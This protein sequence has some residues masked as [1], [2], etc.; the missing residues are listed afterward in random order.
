MHCTQTCKQTFKHRGVLKK[1]DCCTSNKK[2]EKPHKRK[3]TKIF[4]SFKDFAFMTH[5]RVSNHSNKKCTIRK[6]GM[7]SSFKDST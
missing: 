6:F 4:L 7:F 5:I 3:K 2:C 1:G